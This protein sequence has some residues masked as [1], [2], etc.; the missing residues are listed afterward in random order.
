MIKKNKSQTI[1]YYAVLIAFVA[2]ALLVMSG[3]IQRRIMGSYKEAGDRF[4]D[5]EQAVW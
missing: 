1:L 5:G 3:Y 4:S 2:A